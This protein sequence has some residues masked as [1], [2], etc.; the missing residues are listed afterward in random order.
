MTRSIASNK[1]HNL[2]TMNTVNNSIKILINREENHLSIHES[3]LVVEFMVSDNGGG[4]IANDAND[5]LVNC[6]VRAIV[7]SIKLN[8]I[9]G[10]TIKYIDH[11]HA[12][13]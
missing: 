8:T 10:E 6:G 1:P 3:Y 11:R 12:S 7:S 2:A 13:Y 9:S 5:R 4:I